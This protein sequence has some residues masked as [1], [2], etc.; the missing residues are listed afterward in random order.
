MNMLSLKYCLM[1]FG[2]FVI[3][4]LFISAVL[5]IFFL[6]AGIFE[7]YLH[8]NFRI[9]K[10]IGILSLICFSSIISSRYISDYQVDLSK[11]KAKAIVDALEKYKSVNNQYPEKF[12]ELIPEYVETIPNS[13]MGWFDE[14]FSYFKGQVSGSLNITFPSYGG[15]IYLYSSSSSKP[16]WILTD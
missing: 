15:G 6:M 10:Y 7:F 16:K 1:G 3:L 8:R 5:G 2:I 14:P 11:E 12:S 4:M 9:S 13:C